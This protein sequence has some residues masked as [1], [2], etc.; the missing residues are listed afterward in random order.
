[1][2]HKKSCWLYLL[3]GLIGLLAFYVAPF[4][5]GVYYSLTDGSIDNNFVWFVNYTKVWQN[6]GFQIGLAN[7]LL[8]SAMCAPTI[9]VV[10]FLLAGMLRKKVAG[11]GFFRNSLLLPYLMPS[12]AMLIIWL[13]LFDY[14]GVVN[15]LVVALGFDRIRWLEGAEL[16]IPIVLLY[17]WKNLGFSVVIFTAALQAVPE[18][19]YEYASLEGAGPVRRAFCITLPQILPTAFLVFVLAV[20]NAFKIFKEVYFI[21]GA[22]PDVS[23]Y[24]LQ[25]YMNNKFQKLDYQEVTTAA[26]SFAIIVIILFL[27]MY[28]TKSV[29][30]GDTA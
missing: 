7:T 28:R 15:R 10:S 4:C 30:Q 22:Y 3:P 14:G 21:G 18:S 11:D 16:R 9:F 5:L 25:H 23:V 26:Y 1:M 20:V 6:E 17:I 24:T 13:L 12:S 8:L 27:L 2:F 19:L 29:R